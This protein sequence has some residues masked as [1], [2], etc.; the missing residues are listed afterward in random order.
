MLLQQLLSRL[1]LLDTRHMQLQSWYCTIRLDRNS[2][3]GINWKDYSPILPINKHYS[4]Q[5]K[6]PWKS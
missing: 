2:E 3:F 6:A 4:H 1:N 5:H